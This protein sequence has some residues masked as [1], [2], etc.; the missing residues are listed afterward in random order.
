MGRIKEEAWIEKCTVLQEGKSTPNIYYN[1]IAEGEQLSEI[2]DDRLIDIRN[3][4]NQIEKEKQG[5]CHE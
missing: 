4:I 2:S 3:L 1:V 5:E